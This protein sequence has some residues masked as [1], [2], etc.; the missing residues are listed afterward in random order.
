VRISVADRRRNEPVLPR[1]RAS[2]S[3]SPGSVPGQTNHS[4]VG[5]YWLASVVVAR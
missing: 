1:H 3:M 4:A 5:L 2:T